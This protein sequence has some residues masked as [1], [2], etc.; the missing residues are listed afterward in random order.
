MIV[1]VYL[2]MWNSTICVYIYFDVS[3]PVS[4]SGEGY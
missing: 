2:D 4:L 3:P 1:Y